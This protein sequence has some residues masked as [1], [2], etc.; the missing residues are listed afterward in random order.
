MNKNILPKITIFSFS[1]CFFAITQTISNDSLSLSD[2]AFPKTLT[3]FNDTGETILISLPT[4]QKIAP[5]E[6]F[7]LSD[8]NHKNAPKIR[9]HIPQNTDSGIFINSGVIFLHGNVLTIVESYD[10]D[11]LR[12]PNT[13]PTLRTFKKTIPLSSESENFTLSKNSRL[14]EIN[15]KK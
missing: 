9:W 4:D 15:P 1:L 7:F 12:S 10:E 6:S 11:P 2:H 5:G 3:F 13:K 8:E 14:I